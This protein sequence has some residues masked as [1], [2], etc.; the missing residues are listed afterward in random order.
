MNVCYDPIPFCPGGRCCT[1]IKKGGFTFRNVGTV[2]IQI[3]G[4]DGWIP[5]FYHHMS[6][7]RFIGLNLFKWSML[8]SV[9][10]NIFLTR[11]LFE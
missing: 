6:I 9:Y 3:I 11:Y 5:M 4:L 7:D 2:N 10:P 1:P 8:L